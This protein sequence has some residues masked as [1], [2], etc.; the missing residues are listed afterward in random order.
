[1]VKARQGLKRKAILCLSALLASCV[2]DNRA[3]T[4]SDI[5][6]M[7]KTD[8]PM[9]AHCF[10]ENPSGAWDIFATPGYADIHRSASPL[11]VTCKNP[12]GWRGHL[13][14]KAV[15]DGYA[16]IG[17]LVVGGLTSAGMMMVAPALGIAAVA[18]ASL[19]MAGLTEAD[20]L[21]EDRGH[22]Y[23]SVIVVP[24]E[25]VDPDYPDAIGYPAEKP[26]PVSGAR[27][28]G[29]SHAGVATK[30]EQCVTII[31]ITP[32]KEKSAPQTQCVPLGEQETELRN[33]G[34]EKMTQETGAQN[35]GAGATQ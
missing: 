22:K 13:D 31:P 33:D 8:P 30:R 3:G 27:K 24:M 34:G 32:Q 28:G 12:V 7:V 10:L 11:S 25:N 26:T 23:D 14:V 29:A 2:S 6:V 4:S 16:Y 18:G 5:L 17:A 15:Q 9:A 1:M 21:Y 19:G 20:N 35:A